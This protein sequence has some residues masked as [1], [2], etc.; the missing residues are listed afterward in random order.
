MFYCFNYCGVPVIF[1]NSPRYSSVSYS[2][3]KIQIKYHLLLSSFSA[4]SSLFQQLQQLKFIQTVSA[5]TS[6]RFPG[7]SVF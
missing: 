6:S 3:F 1:N 7:N 5:V 4:S 2:S